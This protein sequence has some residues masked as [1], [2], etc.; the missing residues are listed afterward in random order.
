MLLVGI[1]LGA[2][3]F[4][5]LTIEVGQ[6]L[7]LANQLGEQGGDAL[8]FLFAGHVLEHGQGTVQTTHHLLLI[9]THFLDGLGNLLGGQAR[10]RLAQLLEE[11]GD[12]I[13]ADLAQQSRHLIHLLQQFLGGQVILRE[14]VHVLLHLLGDARQLVLERL[15]PLEGGLQF[16]LT[17][18]VR[19]RILHQLSIET[20][21]ITAQ[22]LATAPDLI[23]F[24]PLIGILAIARSQDLHRRGQGQPQHLRPA[25]LSRSRLPIVVGFQVK[26]QGLTRHQIQFAGV[27]GEDLLQ[28]RVRLPG[29]HLGHGQAQVTDAC[30]HRLTAGHLAH[31][32]TITPEG[33]SLGILRYCRGRLR[34]FPIWRRVQRASGIGRLRTRAGD[35]EIQARKT[36]IVQRVHRQGYFRRQRQATI[37][38]RTAQIHHRRLVGDDRHREDQRCVVAQPVGVL[39]VQRKTQGI[40]HL[41]GDAQFLADGHEGQGIAVAGHRPGRGHRVIDATAEHQPRSLEQLQIGRDQGQR[42]RRQAR[43]GRRLDARTQL[44]PQGRMPDGYLSF[45]RHHRSPPET[46]AE[47]FPDSFEPGQPELVGDHAGT[48]FG[49]QG[50]LRSGRYPPPQTAAATHLADRLLLVVAEITGRQNNGLASHHVVRRLSQVKP[51]GGLG[52]GTLPGQ[53]QVLDTAPGS[54]GPVHGPEQGQADHQGGADQHRGSSRQGH[55]ASEF[56]AGGD[57]GRPG[58]DA[59]D[60]NGADATRLPPAI[61]PAQGLVRCNQ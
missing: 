22:S 3:L 56:E 32:L 50:Q 16:L 12:L 38:P 8:Q 53:E 43:V 46:I 17:G 49:G 5:G 59:I 4:L 58:N 33:Q 60:Q 26:D 61:R 45:L 7:L 18:P 47:I 41:H 2:R 48:P 14:G 42:L 54:V 29:V 20:I 23:Q 35:E 51:D 44:G 19:Q 11:F 24:I 57:P 31:Q 25:D 55:Q 13:L 27:E 15:L 21:Q 36:E 52:H 37:V 39:Q 30:G 10:H 1:S 40:A 34:R 6:F 28:R 9:A